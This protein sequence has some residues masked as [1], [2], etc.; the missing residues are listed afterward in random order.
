MI[1]SF[2]RHATI[3]HCNVSDLTLKS[4]LDFTVAL[5]TFF[6]S[7]TAK[8]RVLVNLIIK[9]TE[10]SICCAFWDFFHLIPPSHS[11]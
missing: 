1:V 7:R 10:R 4:L 6:P 5:K 11:E 2:H 9:V 3:F 8:A